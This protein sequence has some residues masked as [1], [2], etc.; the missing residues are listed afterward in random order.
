MDFELSEKQ[1]AFQKEVHEYLKTEIREEVVEEFF[2]GRVS[3]P[4]CRQLVR[5]LGEKG[6]L[7]P[8]WPKEYGG[9]GLSHIEKQI[10]TEELAYLGGPYLYMA[11]AMVGPIIRRYGT[12]EQKK[13]FLLRIA[14]GEIEFALG[15]TE[16]Q[17]GSDLAALQIRAI[18]DGEDYVINGQKTFNTGSE[19]ADYHFLAARTDPNAPKHRGISVFIVDFKTPGITISPLWTMSRCRTNEVFYDDVRVPKKNLVGEKNR[20]FSYILEAL[21]LERNWVVGN[22]KRVFEQLVAYCRETL[23]DGKPLSK[24]PLI[25]QKLAQLATE[26]EL[27]SLLNY[28]VALILD[29]GT[30]PSY[31]SSLAKL[32]GSELDRR[33]GNAGMQILGLY[34]QLQRDS[35]W[36]KLNGVMEYWCQESLRAVITRGTSEIMRNII[37]LRGLRLETK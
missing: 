1:K 11:G 26:I 32:F 12:E 15:Y 10:I 16:P 30:L 14:K 29:G 28:R 8:H 37:A 9:L 21:T 19:N 31:E 20:G 27:S 17:A 23:V 6:W 25:R 4:H 5:K 3:G 24:D 22:A 35:K 2:Y 36:T 18:E 34:G 7:V 33:L 13:E